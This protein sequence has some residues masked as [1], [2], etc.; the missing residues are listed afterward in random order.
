MYIVSPLCWYPHFGKNR[1]GLEDGSACNLPGAA[2]R[3][4]QSLTLVLSVSKTHTS[5]R[6]V[7]RIQKD[8]WPTEILIK[9]KKGENPS[10]K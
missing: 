3:W 7:I 10:Y 1:P 6:G 8:K 4:H 5:L 2:W 9:M